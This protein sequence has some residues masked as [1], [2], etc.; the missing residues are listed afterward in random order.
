MRWMIVVTLLLAGCSAQV[1]LG[2]SFATAPLA[3]QAG[4]TAVEEPDG[5]IVYERAPKTPIEVVITGLRQAQT[6]RS[7]TRQ[8]AR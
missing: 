6:V 5:E 3:T 2:P 1:Q 7:L 4:V 8:L